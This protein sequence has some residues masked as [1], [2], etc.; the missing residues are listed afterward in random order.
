VDISVAETLKHKLALSVAEASE[1]SNVCRSNIYLAVASGELRAKKRGTSTLILP[2]DLRAW[3]ENLP[4]FTTETKSSRSDMATRARLEK[5]R[6]IEAPAPPSRREAAAD[7]A[8]S[9]AQRQ[10]RVLAAAE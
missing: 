5:S 3:I 1:M 10:R 8:R 4:D 6:E 7:R 2:D 9:V